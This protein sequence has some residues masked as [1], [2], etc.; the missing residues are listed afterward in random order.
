LTKTIE[1]DLAGKTLAGVLRSL[2]PDRSWSQVRRLIETRRIE[3]GGELCLDPSR[4]VN[5]GEVLVV[6]SRPA[7]QP[8]QRQPV[9]ICYLDEHLVVV[10]KP[11]GIATVR[12]PS[13]RAWSSRRKALKPTLEDLV[14]PLIAR[15]VGRLR[16]GPLPRLRVVQRL[17]KETSGLVVFARTPVAERELGR[18]FR[19]HSVVRQYLAIIPG[20]LPGQRI[21]T[22]LVRDRGDGRRGSTRLPG[23]GKEAIT[24]VTLVERLARY[25]L[26]SCRL[27]TG[28]THQIRIHLAECGHPL[29]G[30]KVYNR[31]L[32]GEPRPDPSGCP[33]LALHAIELGFA[34]PVTGQALH[35]TMALPDDLAR[36]LDRLRARPAVPG[37]KTIRRQRPS[38]S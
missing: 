5:Q 38:G 11:S 36:F 2:F 20:Y 35:W 6:L 29:C 33:R 34:H 3:L 31:T 21:A 8:S 7:R 12:H 25:T 32:G 30:E 4:R 15:Q 17:D 10:E 24:H 13:E 19:H 22:R 16:K 18:Q 9:V 28:R 26:L 14:P 1:A 27:E 23:V 37:P